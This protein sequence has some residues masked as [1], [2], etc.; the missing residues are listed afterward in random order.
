MRP[1]FALSL[2]FD[3]IRLLHRSDDCWTMIGETDVNVDDL[4]GALGAMRDR[5]AEIEPNNVRTKLIIP[6]DQI[7]WLTVETGDIPD[8]AR[9]AVALAALDG[10]T[11]YPVSD[12]AFDFSS[13]GPL[14]HIAAVARETLD[15]AEM[16]ALEHRFHPVSFVG[17]PGPE[18]FIGE[19]FF[20]QAAH[21]ENLLAPG[22]F[23]MPDGIVV[24]VEGLANAAHSDT[25]HLPGNDALAPG[26]PAS[27]T[28]SAPDIVGL[29]P[30]M[31]P[32]P[33]RQSDEPLAP[34][35][36]P[37]SFDLPEPEEPAHAAEDQVAFKAMPRDEDLT[38]VFDLEAEKP[39][40]KEMAEEDSAPDNSAQ[41]IEVAVETSIDDG[42]L[43]AEEL[44]EG[45]IEDAAAFVA[46]AAEDAKKAAPDVKAVTDVESAPEIEAEQ[47]DIT[48]QEE[49]DPVALAEPVPEAL[50]EDDAAPDITA[51]A[52]ELSAEPKEA[53]APEEEAVLAVEAVEDEA[54]DDS[55]PESLPEIEPEP[56]VTLELES[57]ELDAAEPDP[58]PATPP[59]V[60]EPAPKPK[61][62]IDE[63]PFDDVPDMPPALAALTSRLKRMDEDFDPAPPVGFSTRRK[64]DDT[65]SDVPDIDPIDDIPPAKPAANL[66]R[67]AGASALAAAASLRAP[68]REIPEQPAPEPAG[69]FFGFLRRSSEPGEAERPIIAGPLFNPE[70][71]E[72]MTLFGQRAAKEEPKKERASGNLGLFLSV[73]LLVFVVGV[74]GWASVFLDDG[75]SGLFSPRVNDD[76]VADLQAPDTDTAPQ[77]GQNDTAPEIVL[78]D[79]LVIEDAPTPLGDVR[80]AAIDPSLSDEDAA[81]LD[82]MRDPLPEPTPGPVLSDA[83]LAERYPATGI[84]PIAPTPPDPAGMIELDDIYVAS[85]DPAVPAQDAILLPQ[86]ASLET[87]IPLGTIASPAAAGTQFDLGTNG[88]VRA[89]PEGALSPDGHLVFLGKPPAVPPETPLRFDQ[90]PQLT[91]EAAPDDQLARIPAPV[92][93]S[94]FG[95]ADRTVAPRRCHVRRIAAVSS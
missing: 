86:L 47:V 72:R 35:A 60:A 56:P 24:T 28:I 83:E 34:A 52:L 67:T 40:P 75:I 49:D 14:T 5:A 13:D 64:P 4:A 93:A 19:P 59:L 43:P 11:P 53:D 62:I 2:S 80:L 39:A 63:D 94:G 36:Q 51:E 6:H 91:E 50:Q 20:G 65:T 25:S 54:T 31:A 38:P 84:W 66:P 33:P 1:N 41:E 77:I 42:E 16:F 12:L 90:T 9:R 58:E 81:V 27:G 3:G 71:T 79:A 21:A 37:Y 8:S 17:I 95:R 10:A 89:T 57:E 30:D 26:L 55:L 85:I 32:T 88:L 69:G 82:A 74:G 15:D 61:V 78:P 7:R 45:T 18:S 68:R 73:G 87:D 76:V 48:P 70:E 23:V 92:A 46:D 44:A 22:D 29:D